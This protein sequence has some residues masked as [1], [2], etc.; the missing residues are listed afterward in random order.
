MHSRNRIVNETAHRMGARMGLPAEWD[1]VERMAGTDGAL[2][3]KAPST[4]S[5]AAS[6]YMSPR[7]VVGS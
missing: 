3:K 2:L 5:T 4:G 7:W 6:M 1:V